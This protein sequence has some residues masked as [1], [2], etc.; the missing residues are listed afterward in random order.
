MGIISV[1]KT[2][3]TLLITILLST[4]GFALDPSKAVTQHTIDH[5][6][7]EQGLPQNTVHAVLQT[8]DGYLWLG[9]EEGLARFD[10]DTFSV[11]D[12]NNTPAITHNYISCLYED[13]REELW[14]GTL[15][16]GLL[17][18][19]N[20]IFKQ[21]TKKDG[22]SASAIYSIYED[23]AGNLWIG[24]DGGGLN[25]LK[26][27]EDH[28]TV[29]NEKN[30]LPSNIVKAIH[31]DSEKKLW[32]GTTKGLSRFQNNSFHSLPGDVPPPDEAINVILE[33]S[34]KNLWVG[35]IQGLYRLEEGKFEKIK[36]KEETSKIDII[37]IFEDSDGNLWLATHHSGLIRF[38]DG[39]FS[40]L[41]RKDGLGSDTVRSITGDREGS[42]WVGLGYNGLNRLKDDKFTTIANK[43]GLSD[44]I[45]FS[46]FEDSLGF[47]WIGTNNGLNRYKDGKYQ[48]FTTKEGLTHNAI[49][50]IY[51]DRQGAIWVGTDSGLNR[52]K[53]S[54]SGRYRVTS[55]LEE[56][57]VPA[58]Q[59]DNTGN[60]MTGTQ[61]GVYKITG[62][63]PE[64]F[65]LKS[66]LPT[67][68]VN[69]IHK[70][71]QENLWFSTIRGGVSRYGSGRFTV[72]NQNHGL[73][74]DTLN[75]IY[76]DDGGVL[77][78]GSNNG[79]NR[80]Q[81]GR[82]VT[83]TKRDGLFNNN[84]YQIL[85][86][87]KGYL[88][89]SSNKGIFRVL[90][91]DL[92]ALADGKS[93]RVQ[94]VS[95][96]KADGMR[97]IECNG[98]YKS[99]GFKTK[100]GRLWFP[101]GKGVVVIDPENIKTNPVPP[102]VFIEQ[103]L[104]DGV[105]TDLK[106][107]VVVQ[108]GIKRLE[109]HYTALS[110]VN[111]R[112]IK[113]K[114]KLE[115]FDEQWQDAGNHRAAWY[116]NLDGGTY[117]FRVAA[118]NDDGL[119]NKTGASLSIQV[120]PP[121]WKTWWF[122]LFA[123]ILFAFVSYIVIHFFRKYIN[124]AAFWKKQAYIGKFKIMDRI[125]AGGMGTIYKANNQL[126]RSQTVALKVLRDDLFSDESSRKRFKQEAAIIDQL[127][128]PNIVKIHERGQ[129]GDNLFIAME[130]LVGKTLTQIISDKKKLELPESL[131]IM[132]QVA[133]AITKIHGKNI[134]HR[135]LKPDNIML[136]EKEG[137]RNFVK[138]LDFGL[139][140]TQHQTRLT[141]T[142][143]VIGTINYMSPEQISGSGSFAASDIYAL[144]II[145]YEMITGDKPFLGETTI[146]IMK[147]ILD[148][149]PIEPIR[150][151]F[152]ISFEL[153]RLIMDMLKKEREERPTITEVFSQLKVI[154]NNI[155]VLESQ[156]H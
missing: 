35:T 19:K 99:A 125:G 14:I 21:F 11:L 5:W 72:Y 105:P 132:L 150:F 69:F 135:D 47:L 38:R 120:I 113:F 17:R 40:I 129:S 45:V 49:D 136:V 78:F 85:E 111:P 115:G 123:L 118:C 39:V 106:K 109:M 42:L 6:T 122:N 96:G 108:P 101:T 7:D 55:Y 34:R 44:D 146:D 68:F 142:G 90:K 16:G 119:W 36:V 156:I 149:S 104:L 29:Y 12:S 26:A 139:A 144:G 59:E 77:W 86:D 28:F 23:A 127:D 32:V 57:Y 116:T 100:D 147:Q 155:K 33:D 93:D 82:F 75:C 89:M 30:G 65:P 91:A 74:A 98:G 84:I 133:S 31:M 18:Y 79:L 70:D 73:A 151:R 76:E 2:I 10:G 48:Y 4:S 92:H 87:K 71:K 110:F 80:F 63:E 137:D 130:L 154:N 15:G 114:Y 67:K 112:K 143:I 121:Y 20:G 54:R 148:K 62:P 66:G 13:S 128:H 145:F 140:K 43:E 153:N 83:F 103:M 97:S 58:I 152:D 141:Q 64:E 61:V 22:I 131:H 56:V 46:I 24:T 53:P 117:N 138:L 50:T 124:L 94:S 25:R 1:P 3:V 37:D 107:P 8:G 134:I 9:T 126:E 41:S 95:Y 27:G 52:L 51:E 88:W 60:L 81:N 102:P